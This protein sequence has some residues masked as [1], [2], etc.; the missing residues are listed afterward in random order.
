MYTREVLGVLPVVYPSSF[1]LQQK[2]CTEG[3]VPRDEEGLPTHGIQLLTLKIKVWL[4]SEPSLPVFPTGVTFNPTFRSL[5][6]DE[7]CR[8]VPGILIDNSYYGSPI[9]SLGWVGL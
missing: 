5:M 7:E 2:E 8:E 1:R 4:I 9:L 3:T 6:Y